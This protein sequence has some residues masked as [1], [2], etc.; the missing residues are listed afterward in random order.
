V[1]SPAVE[2]VGVLVVRVWLEDA[3]EAGLRA[4]ITQTLDVARRGEIV[5]VTATRDEV[6]AAVRTWLEAFTAG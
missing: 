2:R 5:I 4:R 6:Y 1:E 3:S